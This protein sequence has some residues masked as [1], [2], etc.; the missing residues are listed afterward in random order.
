MNRDNKKCI[1]VDIDNTL[2]KIN[3]AIVSMIKKETGNSNENT[4]QFSFDDLPMM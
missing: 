1:I 3:E 4:K 2:E